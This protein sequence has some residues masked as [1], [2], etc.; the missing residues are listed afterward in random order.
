MREQEIAEQGNAARNPLCPR[1]VG[2]QLG[3]LVLEDGE[4]SGLEAHDSDGPLLLGFQ[5][6]RED[7]DDVLQPGFGKLQIAEVVQRAAAAQ[8][9]RG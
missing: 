7:V 9:P 3:Q 8:A 2:Q 6:R 1:I 5:H 4:A